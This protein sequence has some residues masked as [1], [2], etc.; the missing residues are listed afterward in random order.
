M[1]ACDV[2]TGCYDLGE[3]IDAFNCTNYACL[4]Q[5]CSDEKARGLDDYQALIDCQYLG[6]ESECFS[7]QAT[8][9]SPLAI[10][11]TS[12]IREVLRGWSSVR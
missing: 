4:D 10:P 8:S 3:C 2:G 1:Q 5:N 6:C 7:G 12:G 11:P 9:M